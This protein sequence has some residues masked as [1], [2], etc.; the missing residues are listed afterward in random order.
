MGMDFYMAAADVVM[1]V[2]M[3]GAVQF[4]K[5]FILTL[6]CVHFI[7]FSRGNRVAICLVK[8]C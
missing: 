5:V 8:S 4:L 2:C 7:Y 6:L 3:F 1:P